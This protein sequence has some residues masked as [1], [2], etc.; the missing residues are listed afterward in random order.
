[1]SLQVTHR[2]SGS[3]CAM[4]TN[5]SYHSVMQEVDYISPSSARV[6]AL[7]L[8]L[9]CALQ[10][11][12]P[13]GGHFWKD[14]RIDSD[15][16]VRL[17]SSYLSS[18]CPHGITLPESGASWHMDSLPGVEPTHEVEF[19][20]LE[21]AR[22]DAC[23]KDAALLAD[24]QAPVQSTVH[25]IVSG[26]LHHAT[27]M[28]RAVHTCPRT[29][30]PDAA[31]A[32][33]CVQHLATHSLMDY[34]LVKGG[35]CRSFPVG[36]DPFRGDRRAGS[37]RKV[38]FNHT[39]MFWFPASRQ[40][41]LP[42]RSTVHVLGSEALLP[43][44]R[45]PNPRTPPVHPCPLPSQETP[46]P[47]H[48]YLSAP[49]HWEAKDRGIHAAGT[50]GCCPEPL[51][52]CMLSCTS[53]F[54][55][56]FCQ[57]PCLEPQHKGIE[58]VG[59]RSP[60]PLSGDSFRSQASLSRSDKECAP[61]WAVEDFVIF[62]DVACSFNADLPNG[63][64]FGPNDTSVDASISQPLKDITNVEADAIL[65]KDEHVG[66]RSP[67]VG[68]LPKRQCQAPAHFDAP[69]CCGVEPQ[70]I[71]EK[72]QPSLDIHHHS[73]PPDVLLHCPAKEETDKVT[74]DL[75]SRASVPVRRKLCALG[76]SCR[77]LKPIELASY[78]STPVEA[79][80]PSDTGA[81][82][83]QGRQCPRRR[84]KAKGSAIR[85]GATPYEP[86]HHQ[87]YV[88]QPRI[89]GPHTNPAAVPVAG[90]ASGSSTTHPY[91]SFDSVSSHKSLQAERSWPEWRYVTNAILLSGLPGNP[92]GRAL[93][94][95]VRGFPWP[96]VA[97]TVARWQDFRR[98]IVFD[99]RSVEGPLVVYD[100]KPGATT[101]T[102]LLAP[103]GPQAFLPILNA[104]RAGLIHCNVNG[105]PASPDALL[106][107]NAD[108]VE[109]THEELRRRP[110]TPPLP[111]EDAPSLL[112]DTQDF[113][114]ETD[115]PAGLP[116]SSSSDTTSLP[117]SRGENRWTRHQ[118]GPANTASQV[119]DVK[120][121]LVSASSDAPALCT[122][123]DPVKQ[124]ELTETAACRGS[125]LLLNFALSKARHL[126]LS[127]DGR[128]L[129]HPL[130]GLPKPQV[131]IHSVVHHNYVVV[132]VALGSGQFCTLAV[133][134]TASAFEFFLLLESVCK[135]PKA[136]RHM[137][138]KGWVTCVINGIEVEDAFAK[139]AMLVADSVRIIKAPEIEPSFAPER[140]HPLRPH[141]STREGCFTLHCPGQPPRHWH[142]SPYATPSDVH[143]S[144]LS[145]G[146]LHP[147]G[148]A[149]PL[150]LSPV[151]GS[152]GA[153]FL[154]LE[155]AHLRQSHTWFVFDLRRVTHP[156]LVTFWAAPRLQRLSLPAVTD[157]LLSEFPT[158]DPI[159]SVYSGT[160][161][162]EDHTHFSAA[163]ALLAT[164]VGAPQDSLRTGRP[165]DPAVFRTTDSLLFRPGFLSSAFR[166]ERARRRISTST[167][168]TTVPFVLEDTWPDSSRSGP[169]PAGPLTRQAHLSDPAAIAEDA[170][171]C[172]R[173]E[174][175][176]EVSP[177]EGFPV[178]VF[179]IVR[180][181]HLR[182]ARNS[183]DRIS[184]ILEV[185]AGL[186]YL[187]PPIAFRVLVDVLPD[188]PDTQIVVWTEPAPGQRVLPVKIGAGSMEVCT[189]CHPT[190]ATPHEAAIHIA[191]KCAGNDRLQYR[192]ASGSLA[193]TVAG[194]LA[195]PFV[196]WQL[197]DADSAIIEHPSANSSSAAARVLL[198]A[199][200]IAPVQISE[201]R[202][203]PNHCEVSV[204]RYGRPVTNVRA[205]AHLA[206]QQ[207][208]EHLVQVCGLR[209]SMRLSFP[210]IMPAVDPCRLHVILH[211]KGGPLLDRIP[212]L[213]DIRRVASATLEPWH[214]VLLPPVC[215]LA[216]IQRHMMEHFAEVQPYSAAYLNY[217]RLRDRLLGL[218]R[219][220]VITLLGMVLQE[221]LD[222]VNQDGSFGPLCYRGNDVAATRTGLAQFLA[223][224]AVGPFSSTSTTTTCT[225]PYPPV[226]AEASPLSDFALDICTVFDPLYGYRTLS[227]DLTTGG[228]AE[229][230]RIRQVLDIPEGTHMRALDFEIVC[231]PS[232]QFAL[233]PEVAVPGSR[234]IVLD[235]TPFGNGISVCLATPGQTLY[236]LLETQQVPGSE[237]IADQLHSAQCVCL[238]NHVVV[239]PSGPLGALA[240]TVHFYLLRNAATFSD[241]Q[242]SR[243]TTVS[244][245][246][247]G[248]G[249][250]LHPSTTPVSFGPVP[251]AVPPPVPSQSR[252]TPSDG[253]LQF[254][255][256]SS[257]SAGASRNSGPDVVRLQDW[258][259]RY[260]V[261]G[262]QEGAINR[263]REPTWDSAQCVADAVATAPRHGPF[264]HGRALRNPLP[265]LFVPQ[266]LLSRVDDS[267]G[268]ITI[269]VDLRPLRL[270]V[271]ATTAHFGTTLGSLLEGGSALADALYDMGRLS[272]P[273]R[274][275]LNSRPAYFNTALCA[276]SETITIEPDLQPE[277]PRMHLTADISATGAADSAHPSW[278][279]IARDL[280]S[281]HMSLDQLE[282]H[283]TLLPQAWTTA[284]QPSE[285]ALDLDPAV[286]ASSS[287]PPEGEAGD[288][289]PAHPTA[290]TSSVPSTAHRLLRC[291]LNETGEAST[292][293]STTFGP[294]VC[295]FAVYTSTTTTSPLPDTAGR[296]LVMVACAIP[297]DRPRCM[298]IRR[299][300]HVCQILWEILQEPGRVLPVTSAWTLATCPRTFPGRDSGRLV[301]TTLAS[302]NP[303]WCNAWID[304]R[305][306][307]ARLFVAAVELDS[308]ADD[309]VAQFC[310]G[311]TGMLVV[312][313]GVLVRGTPALRN[314]CVL[315]ICHTLSVSVT[316]PLSNLFQFHPSLQ[317]LRFPLRVPRCIL[318]L[319]RA[320]QAAA[321]WAVPIAYSSFRREFFFRFSAEVQARSDV[322]GILPHQ[323]ILAICCP[324]FGV[325]KITAG[326]RVAPMASQLR[327]FLRNA[328][329]ELLDYHIHD[330]GEFFGEATYYVLSHPHTP[331]VAW[332][333]VG[334][335]YDDV[336]FLHPGDNPLTCIPCPQGYYPHVYRCEGAWGLYGLRAGSPTDGPPFEASLWQPH[337]VIE[338]AD[339][340]V[341]TSS[342]EAL[343]HS[344][345]NV[346]CHNGE[347]QQAPPVDATQES[348]TELRAEDN[349]TGHTSMSAAVTPCEGVERESG[350][351]DSCYDSSDA[352]T[353]LQLPGQPSPTT[354]TSSRN[355]PP[356][357]CCPDPAVSDPLHSRSCPGQMKGLS[358]PVSES[359]MVCLTVWPP[360][361]PPRVMHIR[362]A[363][364]TT[365]VDATLSELFGRPL[366]SS[367][368]LPVYPMCEEG[369][370][371]ALM[372]G[373][374]LDS[375]CLIM[376]T[377]VET[378]HRKLLCVPLPCTD[379]WLMCQL[380]FGLGSLWIGSARWRGSHD[381]AYQ[382]MHLSY[383]APLSTEGNLT[384][385]V[386]QVATP[387]RARQDKVTRVLPTVAE[388][389]PPTAPENNRA[390]CVAT[391][392]SG[393]R[394]KADA[395]VRLSLEERIPHAIIPSRP[396]SL[397]CSLDIL[398]ALLSDMS[399]AAFCKDF[400]QLPNPHSATLRAMKS[401]KVWNS[402]ASPDAVSFYTDGSF[403]HSTGTAGWAVVALVR[404]EGQWQ[405]A[406]FMSGPLAEPQ[407]AAAF[408]Y[409]CLSP[410]S[411]ELVAL[412]HALCA[413]SALQG[414]HCRIYYDAQAAAAIADC[415][416]AP[417]KH[418]ALAKGLASLRHLAMLQCG[419]LSME[420]VSA[421]QG[422]AWNEAADT[423]AKAAANQAFFCCPEG[424]RLATVLKEGHLPWL[425]WTVDPRC[426]NGELPALDSD[427]T[428]VAAQAVRQRAHPLT[429]IPGV[430]RTLLHTDTSETKKG[431]FSISCA[432]YNCTTVRKQHDRE[433]LAQ[434]FAKDGLHVLGIQESRTDPGSRY[435]QG[436]YL[437][438][439]SPSLQGNLGC[440]IWLNT[441]LPVACA[442]SG[443]TFFE[444][445][446][447]T[448]ICR[449]P[450]LTAISVMAGKQ[451][452]CVISG[453][454][455]Y[456]AASSQEKDAWWDMLDATFRKFPRNALPLLCIDA[457]ARVLAN[458][459]STVRE[460]V[461]EG[462]NAERFTAFLAEHC[463]QTSSTHDQLGNPIF[464]W[465]S[466]AGKPAL[467]DYVAMP[468]ELQPCAITVG[469][470]PH[471]VDPL[472]FDHSPVMITMTWRAEARPTSAALGM[473][474][475]AMATEAGKAMIQHIL[476]T[477]PSPHWS[478]HP[479]D[480]LQLINDHVHSALLSAFPSTRCSPAKRHISE[481]LWGAVRQRRHCRRIIFRNKVLW[482]KHLAALL[483]N[484]WK[485]V[486]KQPRAADTNAAAVARA[487][488]PRRCSSLRIANA[489]LAIVL[490]NLQQCIRKMDQRDAAAFA[491][492]QMREAREAGPAE[493]AQLLRSVLKQ[494]RRYK[495]PRVS[496]AIA[497]DSHLE[498]DPR[499]VTDIL[500]ASFARPEQGQ[501]RT[502]SDIVCR[503]DAAE[504][505]CSAVAVTHLPTVADLTAA[506]LSMRAG[507]ASG[508]S[509]I[510][511]EVYKYGAVEAAHLHF[512]LL[513]KAA[514][515]GVT[516]L[517][518]KGSVAVAIPKPGKAPDSVSAWRN[519]AL[520]DS[521]AKGLSRALR[522][523]LASHLRA[524]AEAGQHG[525]LPGDQISTPAL[526]VQSYLRMAARRQ[527]SGAV[528]FIDG[529]TAYYS[530][531][532]QAL[533]ANPSSDDVQFLEQ[534]FSQ[535][536]FC[537][538]DQARLI[539][540]L[541][542]AGEFDIAGVN[543]TLQDFLRQTLRGTWFTMKGGCDGRPIVET[544]C[545]TVPGTPLADMLYAFVQARFLRDLRE[546]LH[547]A[548][549]TATISATAEAAPTPAWADDV[550]IL[551]G[552]GPAEDL[553]PKLAQVT[554]RTEHFSRSAGVALNFEPG[555]TEAVCC[556]RGPK[557]RQVKRA[558]LLDSQPTLPVR[559]T[560]GRNIS[561]RIV[562]KY[563]HLGSVVSYCG[564]SSADIK[565][566]PK[567]ATPV[568]RRLRSTL[569]RNPNLETTEKVEL[570]R[571]LVI[572]KVGFGS[573]L[574]VPSGSRDAS[575][576]FHAVGRF[577]RQSFGKVYG[578]SSKLLTDDEV[579]HAL[580]ALS[581]AQFFRVERVRQLLVV[582]RAGPGFLWQVLQASEDWL[583]MAFQS[584]D[585]VCSDLKV[586][587]WRQAPVAAVDK[588]HFC[589]AHMATLVS[590]PHKY[591]QFAK[592]QIHKGPALA[593]A[594]RLSA[595]ALEGWHPVLMPSNDGLTFSCPRCQATFRSRSALAVHLDKR[596]NTR[597][598]TK[599]ASGTFC[600]VCSTEWWSTYRL[601]EHLRR[602]PVCRATW[603]ESDLPA[604][605][606]WELTGHRSDKAW[607]PPQVACAAQPFWATLR[608]PLAEPVATAELDSDDQLRAWAADMDSGL[609][610]TD[611]SI[612]AHQVLRRL[613]E[614]PTLT[615]VLKPGPALHAARAMESCL[616]QGTGIRVQS[617]P[618]ACLLEERQKLWIKLI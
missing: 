333:L 486:R 287:T 431:A 255:S 103:D 528:L 552:L 508:L 457:N 367:C 519:I 47:G 459:P 357:P 89:P 172:L 368:L 497:V 346:S 5:G 591:V 579:C 404:Q 428:P 303:F 609:K 390:F 391:P 595:K 545:G 501:Y 465:L 491:R 251:F 67:V 22:Q 80:P 151:Q 179:D 521:A 57:V 192:I 448:F 169:L 418:Q 322:V 345:S 572:A 347:G 208:L 207:L 183:H 574:W 601:R 62:Q 468:Q 167:T 189:I 321:H 118:A 569:L 336:L 488:W 18:C 9:E 39:V 506:F 359:G 466:P 573:A 100:A 36:R 43:R 82:F 249:H 147:A 334:G 405:W 494:G 546:E 306:G 536:G 72:D 35:S 137:M 231:L 544:R 12:D 74:G 324:E 52:P 360:A 32:P 3:V 297:G 566:K 246:E 93:R 618:F 273:L 323:A 252:A 144:L 605:A 272:I 148:I 496:P 155:P 261:I 268:R 135:A 516:P 505:P 437:C 122:I 489:R 102:A 58:H 433:W 128:V 498:V 380:D 279:V 541:R 317:V 527:M 29:H 444:P 90:S 375:S 19:H 441:Q 2:P 586:E 34:P 23:S 453:H 55:Q 366:A 342:E 617:G 598:L 477:C 171:T 28:G 379:R 119:A 525:A 270:G 248:L 471:F 271:T 10:D 548:G 503:S 602:D 266:V 247:P 215:T 130:P 487:K 407:H 184:A 327:P 173:E 454:A 233:T 133:E 152:N 392:P 340:H 181:V 543:S 372:Q 338:P 393:A 312:M 397:T 193:M 456:A 296:P 460:A 190:D 129:N 353:L 259:G 547:T 42:E 557:S 551:L 228:V 70:F 85:I 562:S 163:H 384:E 264:L 180:D 140:L 86:T 149:L 540:H 24:E 269:A 284:L 511:A 242:V 484:A 472:G 592:S 319:E 362:D 221:G 113:D 59:F 214:V 571:S 282:Q 611:L 565:A 509:A 302:Q 105:I 612:W 398:L 348:F 542:V 339:M 164:V 46:S 245:P 403:C 44:P 568:F 111:Q 49:A 510:P 132:P 352:S 341:D 320:R 138:L 222:V 443:D 424:H 425:W 267:V 201:S 150:D 452:F 475:K 474:R 295:P 570:V 260:T 608:P 200:N 258:E 382:G 331:L 92:V 523:Q 588:L 96:Q 104:L 420:H 30:H 587:S 240:D 210:A 253:E 13:H 238:V 387:C 196:A 388:T 237:H 410:H 187:V 478:V 553:L 176:A 107:A 143:N 330:T 518:W 537:Q 275:R 436:E 79:V 224:P 209:G 121:S 37:I 526:C 313:D 369:F 25:R 610:D 364:T 554:A 435:R 493:M 41:T 244:L 534:L 126:G 522:K 461:P 492:Q 78:I 567:A 600:Y 556:F 66:F 479:D 81:N 256:D 63:P 262:T 131:C 467:L 112:P 402:D 594:T 139:D 87:N 399:L 350:D 141:P 219:H 411:A 560:D 94:H 500:E 344:P 40:L 376:V 33:A 432:T 159:I 408:G 120:M 414:T 585:E 426:M 550:S 300:E 507:K 455:P 254:E 307:S 182:V 458:T 299:G 263:H 442:D 349:D 416:A 607:R 205:G 485:A 429:S 365:E 394:G 38:S 56:D 356:V 177:S 27:H 212:C 71:T 337:R 257:V 202:F 64:G 145:E 422:N 199:E 278:P 400:S 606:A 174:V 8:E 127:P 351:T 354:E 54:Y 329:P 65:Q 195:A 293:T 21:T 370:H 1:M 434:C 106:D 415:V 162:V 68:L 185:L 286:P 218:H 77:A 564:S 447:V 463:M 101:A 290:E 117:A 584:M 4:D 26:G 283:C 580:G 75:S 421:H 217:Q 265:E 476:A 490:R 14:E 161:H 186:D 318:D 304:L 530:V 575:S 95:R 206:P 274:F 134:R 153:H 197:A 298:R 223:F 406:G 45:F 533:F 291:M 315:T 31:P 483:F 158:L 616:H 98:T 335:E 328:W 513:L 583:S 91:T 191:L 280:G 473:D 559:L 427:G 449:H 235:L 374:D 515:T 305:F 123:F 136:L 281:A 97:V 239:A 7:Q 412:L 332:F 308:T 469:T 604:A 6:L 165:P 108:V 596:H 115:H 502:I 84:P 229:Q 227:V 470:P 11:H 250:A 230:H 377:A 314:G 289:S 156:P 236:D 220:S 563:T 124:Y 615:A 76:P 383:K 232:P 343:F 226:S 589:R 373:V 603:N 535:L 581:P 110:P 423:A 512:P 401:L 499:K 168:T 285:G 125:S 51:N 445:H 576:C 355:T 495:P 395:T 413:A 558:V 175:A 16:E 316:E 614:Q 582:A 451:L 48:N 109:F 50:P 417:T 593:K 555:K 69:P 309:I 371:C 114:V 166:L 520:F 481:E 99:A 577:W 439:C 216:D 538:E 53:A 590:L 504:L 549:L 301:L 310:P 446:S 539:A 213:L 178:A 480:H 430:P 203:A 225:V 204:H 462:D 294:W 15:D 198:P 60:P 61:V 378:G 532:R 419:S 20:G 514:V 170:M 160:E 529:K 146:T 440:Q 276:D 396:M 358:S 531:I 482:H 241:S 597:L 363:A 438:F 599:A 277:P 464:S 83:P 17:T 361:E 578:K 381:G 450:R 188:L 211:P 517:L 389:T 561:L 409:D 524:H 116:A 292:T 325:C 142:A 234:S 154:A 613:K 288:S 243:P 88:W 194:S 311:Q 386:M 385:R 157:L 73:T 326:F